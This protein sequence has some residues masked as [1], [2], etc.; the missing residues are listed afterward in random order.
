MKLRYTPE[1]RLDLAEA[2]KKNGEKSWTEPVSPSKPVA[3]ELI[4][5]CANLKQYPYMGGSLS[6][7]LGQR[8]S[9][10]YLICGN[11]IIFYQVQDE[12]ISII[13]IL[14]ESTGCI[15]LLFYEEG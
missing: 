9:M 13:R 15:R 3:E 5:S 11:V 10:R 7:K 14:D 8:S 12:T 4:K 2:G 6:E 1:A